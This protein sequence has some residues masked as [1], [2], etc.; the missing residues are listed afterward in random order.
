MA[1]LKP[2]R[3][4]GKIPK[5]ELHMKDIPE[6]TRL[7]PCAVLRCECKILEMVALKKE[8]AVEYAE[9]MWNEKNT[10]KGE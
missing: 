8:K 5:L 1:E 10:T 7:Y 4:C 6:A 9:E 2:C 3:Y